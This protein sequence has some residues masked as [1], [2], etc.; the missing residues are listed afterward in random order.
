MFTGIVEGMG[1]VVSLTPDNG[2]L[3]TT[4]KLPNTHES[5]ANGASVAI[6]GCCLTVLE[7]QDALLTFAIGKETLQR[8]NLNN[9]V[10]GTFVNFERPLQWQERLH[11]HLVSG[12]VDCRGQVSAT[13][14]IGSCVR[15]HIAVDRQFAV[16]T[17]YKGSVCL[18]GVSLTINQLEPQGFVVDLLPY[19]NQ[20]TTL[21]L[22]R[23]GDLVNVEFDMFGKYILRYLEVTHECQ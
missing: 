18:D 5:F 20:H 19:T 6:N 8:T 17:V 7:Q 16:N 21:G 13:E 11:G 1:E 9:L 15:L 3:T 4:I 23:Q 2:H 14:Q 10:V 22:R 12:H